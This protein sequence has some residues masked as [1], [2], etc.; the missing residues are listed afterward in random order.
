MGGLILIVYIMRTT[1]LPL[2]KRSRTGGMALPGLHGFKHP[3]VEDY[4]Y[5]ENHS[6]D[7]SDISGTARLH[8]FKTRTFGTVLIRKKSQWTSSFVPRTG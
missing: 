4:N 1:D 3:N 8:R 5:I 7:G 2:P 6:D